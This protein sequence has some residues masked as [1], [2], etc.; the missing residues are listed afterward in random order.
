M[1]MPKSFYWRVAEHAEKLRIRKNAP[2][3]ERLRVRQAIDG[4]SLRRWENLMFW[5]PYKSWI[6]FKD[7]GGAYQWLDFVIEYQHRPIVL[8][9]KAGHRGGGPKAYEKENMEL[10]KRF[11]SERGTPFL[12]LGRKN[13]ALEY[14]FYIRRFLMELEGEEGAKLELLHPHHPVA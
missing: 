8:L 9:F 3:I 12:I 2:V 5:N 1:K 6:D 14:Q 7:A 10:K 13:T 4:L 11:L